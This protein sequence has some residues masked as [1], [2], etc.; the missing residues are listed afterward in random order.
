V[1]ER[2]LPTVLEGPATVAGDDVR[3]TRHP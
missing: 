3:E 2:W 1:V